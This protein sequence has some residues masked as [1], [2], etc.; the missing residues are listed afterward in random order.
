MSDRAV[1][2]A[3]VIAAYDEAPHIEVLTQ[4]LIRV[5]DD[6]PIIRS[7]TL[8]YVVDGED[9]TAQIV[10]SLAARRKEIR[11]DYQPSPAGLG[12]AF[13]RGFGLVPEDSD[14]VVTMDADLN[15]Q[16]EEIPRLLEA[17]I[18][19]NADIVV[20]SRHTARS[21]IE[22]E[23]FGKTIVSRRMRL[24]TGTTVEDMT[25]GF[26]VYRAGFVRHLEY[27]NNG[28][29]FLPELL[30]SAASRGARVVK[31]PIQFAGEPKLAIPSTGLSY[32]NLLA[33]QLFRSLLSMI[34]AGWIDALL[35]GAGII[36]T[37][38]VLVTSLQIIWITYFPL[39]LFDRWDHWR[40]YLMFGKRYAN[41]L[42]FQQNE[43]RIALARIF[44]WI[45]HFFFHAR[46]AFL[47]VSIVLVQTFSFILLW[48][49]AGRGR[50]FSRDSYLL[51]GCFLASSMFSMQQFSNLTDGL[52]IAFVGVYCTAIGAV[53]AL[54]RAAEAQPIGRGIGKWIAITCIAAILSTYSMANG[55]FVWPVLILFAVWLRLPKR[56]AILLVMGTGA[57]AT[58]YL[59][60]YQRPG[61]HANPI[62]SLTHL[63]QMVEY[64]GAY[65]GSPID[66]P[67]EPVLKKLGFGTDSARVLCAAVFGWIGALAA[68]AGI[69]VVWVKRDR[70][71]PAEGALAHISLFILIT[72]AAVASGR[73]NLPTVEALTYRYHT[74]A[75]IFWG[76]LVGLAWSK[77]EPELRNPLRR[78]LVY[79]GMVLWIFIGM[80]IERPRELAHAREY[81]GLIAESQSAL[82][83]GVFDP[84]PWTRAYHTPPDIFAA[85][86]YLR[87]NRLSVFTE[88]W[89]RWPGTLIT[90][91]FVIDRF[92]PCL[93]RFD[94]ATP[95][96]S[97]EMPGSRVAGWAWDEKANRPPEAVVLADN[98][99]RIVGV[100]KDIYDRDDVQRAVPAIM[101]AKTG[102]RGYIS[103][104]ERRNVT[105]YLLESDGRS[106]CRLNTLPTGIPPREVEASELSDV[107]QAP[108][109]MD[110]GW[111][112]NGY[113][114]SMGKPGF[115]GSVYGS[116]IGSG[117]HAGT[118]RIGPLQITN[119]TAFALP[120]TT[121]P[122]TTGL[123]VRVV[124]ATTANLV[125]SLS[126]PQN[127]D[128][129]WFWAVDL[130]S[131]ASVQTVEIVAEDNGK[132]PEQWLAI[133]MPHFLN[134]PVLPSE[135][136]PLTGNDGD[137]FVSGWQKLG[138]GF[139]AWSIS[140]EGV[141]TYRT[142]AGPARS[143]RLTL[144]AVTGKNP[145]AFSL[146]HEKG[147]MDGVIPMTNFP[148][149]EVFTVRLPIGTGPG[150]HK[151]TITTKQLQSPAA[152]G[153]NTDGT[154]LGLGLHS[155][156]A[157]E[158]PPSSV[159]DVRSADGPGTCGK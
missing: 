10:E 25:S 114:P 100:A 116:W 76:C 8:I 29:A 130:P 85:V 32:F 143:L 21:P 57:L 26:R 16:P 98:S 96:Q 15:H 156:S 103:G 152:Q 43:H 151:V 71:Q 141:L 126:P 148:K 153:Y 66:P 27:Q 79:A 132:D 123:V 120:L 9:G 58:A 23:P 34:S 53:F 113:Q 80:V 48:R 78:G 105:A 159:F 147:R 150:V 20:G 64:S 40:L 140:K 88:E 144:L 91:H 134:P 145:V 6:A 131:R 83:A 121:G 82:V 69:L 7:W 52:N 89:T 14:W 149:I 142:V 37:V 67:A 24:M 65:L 75:L 68:I 47:I 30:I 72:A 102:W 112:E 55:L 1:T 94:A 93:G 139:G 36:F 18:S 86:D 74:S 107:V 84:V 127:H 61:R 62:E 133:G 137:F 81:A 19:K 77:L 33:R 95:L 119:Q 39:P 122:V 31:E 97:A 38:S 108:V 90:D 17:A 154:P 128:G 11:L 51:L 92:S 63:S 155:L 124:D 2:L 45:D 125:A 50:S 5:L 87:S 44:I 135:D 28:F 60:G 12:F 109:K 99:L 59:W 56:Y 101:S 4:R 158:C 106:V 42:F 41:F 22:R 117:A 118:F 35:V 3:V 49:L 70:F 111:K 104:G 138:P 46:G 157:D 110:D 13:R 115:D 54:L 73:I 129:W 136:R 146:I